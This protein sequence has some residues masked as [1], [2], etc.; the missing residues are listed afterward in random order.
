[1]KALQRWF[2]RYDIVS[3]CFRQTNLWNYNSNI[4]LAFMTEQGLAIKIN[5]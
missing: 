5:K 4:T 3:Q 2:S 1:V